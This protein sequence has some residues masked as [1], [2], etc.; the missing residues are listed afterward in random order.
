MAGTPDALVRQW[1]DQLWNNGDEG[2]IDRLLAP[3]AQVF[4]LASGDQPI[5][6]PEA[7][8]GFYRQFRAGFSDLKVNVMRTVTEG[9]W[10]AA[11]C[12]CVGTH[13][14]PFL[15]KAATQKAVD[16]HGMVMIR[17]AGG[18][19]VEGR[20]SFDFLTCYQ[21]IDLVPQFDPQA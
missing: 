9:D 6:G 13:T 1:F 16:F 4:G 3:N 10:V 21:Q 11:S 5:V 20:N 17:I 14:G 18:Q 7:F 15:G 19:L 12:H 8:K 2:A